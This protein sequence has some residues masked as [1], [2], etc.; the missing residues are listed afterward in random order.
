MN[1]VDFRNVFQKG[2]KAVGMLLLG[3]IAYFVVMRVVIRLT[4]TVMHSG[5]YNSLDRM[6]LLNL[7]TI[8]VM[9]AGAYADW[10]SRLWNAYS[11]YPSIL[12]KGA[13]ALFFIIDIAALVA[14]L[15]SKTRGIREKL[16][17][18]AL[19]ALLPLGMN[20]IYVLT[21]NAAHDLMVYPIFLFYLLTLLLAEWLYRWCKDNGHV[22]IT[23]AGKWQKVICILLIGVCMYGNARFANGMYVKKNLE[24]D[25]YLSLMTR[26]V[27]RMEATPGY[28]PGETPVAV[29]GLPNTFNQ[30]IPGFKDYWNVTGMTGSNP[31]YTTESSRIQAYFDYVMSLPVVMADSETLARLKA[32]DSVRAMPCYPAE[33]FLRFYDGTLVVKLGQITD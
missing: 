14:F 9:I 25:G 10:L 19:T 28:Q 30:V 22:F 18:V 33:G 20:M 12:I 13:T 11:S 2:M 24:F 32:D 15:L 7:D 3:A 8:G 1:G 16:L 29:I 5:E 21:L 31:I 6:T 17:C 23:A 4:G 27:G 26:I